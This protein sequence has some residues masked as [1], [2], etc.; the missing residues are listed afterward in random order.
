[1]RRALCVLLLA[2]S[3][4][5][6]CARIPAARQDNPL[7]LAETDAAKAEKVVRRVLVDMRFEI[8][9]P[10]SGP[11]VVTTVPLTGAQWFESWRD[12]SV[13]VSERAG[14]SLHTTRRRVT[15]TVIPMD[16]GSK[17]LVKVLKERASAPNLAPESVSHSMHLFSSPEESELIRQDELAK[18]DYVW[19]SLGHDEA[20]EQY[21][22]NRFQKTLASGEP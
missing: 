20:L 9:Y 19:I 15:V 21:L 8:E 10:A 6:G 4:A 7:I 1:M 12:D 3:A 2:A 11:G 13:G 18:T 22:L 16:R 5:A 17:V 14:A